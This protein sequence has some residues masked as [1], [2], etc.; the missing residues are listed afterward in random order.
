MYYIIQYILIMAQN[1]LI[2]HDLNIFLLLNNILFN[3]KVYGEIMCLIDYYIHVK[4]HQTSEN[5]KVL[6]IFKLLFSFYFD[7]FIRS[8]FIFTLRIKIA[9]KLVFHD[10][11]LYL[12]PLRIKRLQCIP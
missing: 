3:Q 8:L 9:T 7:H 5:L 1:M 6:T 2:I 12:Q 10:I 11:L 4:V